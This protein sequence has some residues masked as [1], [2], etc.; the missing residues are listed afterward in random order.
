MNVLVTGALGFIGKHMCQLLNRNGHTVF[1][2]DKDSTEAELID[3]IS[4]ADF[5][6]HL[7]G[8]N[9]PMTVEEFYDG[10][11]NFS[12]KLVDLIKKS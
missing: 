10:N 6:V 1:E 12:A 3:Y 7:A 8:I 5:V 11:A 4:K 2:Y 9:R